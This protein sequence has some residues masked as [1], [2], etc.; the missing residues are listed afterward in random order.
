MSSHTEDAKE[1]STGKVDSVSNTI[2]ALQSLQSA[3][4]ATAVFPLLGRALSLV[5]D[6]VKGIQ[7]K[8]VRGTACPLL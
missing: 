4:S 8:K 6:I 5:L 1:G 3:T 2:N 7:S